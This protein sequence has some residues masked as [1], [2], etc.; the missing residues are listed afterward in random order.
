MGVIGSHALALSAQPCSALLCI[1]RWGL[2]AWLPRG[3]RAVSVPGAQHVAVS[4]SVHVL[5]CYPDP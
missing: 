5:G 2:R 4:P 1:T 3:R